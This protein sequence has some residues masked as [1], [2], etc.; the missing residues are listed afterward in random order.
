MGNETEPPMTDELVVLKA[1]R[2]TWCNLQLPQDVARILG[3]TW[4]APAQSV[5]FFASEGRRA[6]VF[7]SGEV[8]TRSHP[9]ATAR[10]T[11]KMVFHLPAAVTDLLGIRIVKTRRGRTT[12]DMLV[13]FMPA[14]HYYEYRRAARSQRKLG[15]S[16]GERPEVYVA[17]NWPAMGQGEAS[18][19][20]TRVMVPGGE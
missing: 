17:R 5:Q 2:P 20:L 11:E 15:Y 13:W 12:D 18:P 9:V 19:G 14:D 10:L 16:P 6:R 7:V 4:G 8:G 1:I 3:L